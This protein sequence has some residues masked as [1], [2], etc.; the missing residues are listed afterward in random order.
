MSEEDFVL[1]ILIVVFGVVLATLI[2]RR[3]PETFP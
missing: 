1:N 2:A 3:I